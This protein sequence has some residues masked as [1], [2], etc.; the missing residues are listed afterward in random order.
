MHVG[1]T[2][3]NLITHTSESLTK[4]RKAN[5][6]L[7]HVPDQRLTH[8]AEEIR[9][10]SD[11]VQSYYVTHPN[12]KNGAPPRISMMA[13]HVPSAAAKNG[14]TSTVA[15][16]LNA[17]KVRN[18]GLSGST[19]VAQ[20][21]PE[22]LADFTD[23]TEAAKY[24]VFHHPE[25]L[26]LD[27]KTSANVLARIENAPA[28]DALVKNLNEQ[29]V[30]QHPESDYDGWAVGVYLL[31]QDGNRIPDGSRG[32][33]WKYEYTDETRTYMKP[34]VQQALLA[35]RNDKT[36]EGIS[37]ST[38]FGIHNV[39]ANEVSRV[40]NGAL[41][42]S[43]YQYKVGDPDWHHGRQVELTETDGR[44]L[45][46]TVRN[47]YFRYLGVFARF[48][49]Y[50]GT[51]LTPIRLADIP[52]P[53]RPRS[54][55][56]D[57]VYTSY[58]ATV[59]DRP[60]LMGI[61]IK[62]YEEAEFH[63]TLPE[64]ASA[65]D[66]LCGT[67]GTGS[68]PDSVAS[69]ENVQAPG[70]I[71]TGV[72]NLAIPTVFL[73]F[74]I[75]SNMIESEGKALIAKVAGWV[76][77][78]FTGE[79]VRAGLFS[80]EYT[81]DAMST[82]WSIEILN[83]VIKE[84]PEVFLE[85]IAWAAEVSAE[86]G[87][88]K[89]VPVIGAI[90]EAVS[91]TATLAELAETIADVALSPWVIPTTVTST[92]DLE[93]TIHPDKN[94]YQFPVA[95]TQYK[96]VAHL[97]DTLKYDTGWM[98][99]APGNYDESRGVLPQYTFTAIPSGGEVHV[100]V[101]FASDSFWIAAYGATAK[102]P[103]LIPEKQEKLAL[104]LTITEN[105]V[106]LTTGTSYHHVSRL[107]MAAAGTHTWKQTSTAPAST[108]AQLGGNMS[109]TLE[110]LTQITFNMHN[111]GQNGNSYNVAVLGY[112]WRGKGT[113]LSPCNGGGAGAPLFTMQ[114]IQ[115]ATANPDALLKTL[116]CGL[117]APVMPGYDMLGAA[118]GG[119]FILAYTQDGTDAHTGQP[120]YH[121]HVR[122]LDLSTAGA[123]SLSN[124]PSWGRFAS[125][126][127][128]SVAVHGTEFVLAL[129]PEKEM[130]EILKLPDAPYARDGV[131]H[132][133]T[134][135]GK[136]GEYVGRLHGAVA[137]ALTR[138]GNT[139][140]VL[141]Q[142]NNRIQAFNV[143][144]VPVKYFAGS[145]SETVLRQWPEDLGRTITY[146]DMSLE[147][148]GYIYVLSYEEPGTETVQY[149]L[150]TYNPDGTKLSRTRS[151][152]AAKLTVDQWRAVYTLNYELLPP[153]LTNQRPEPSVS[154]WAAS[155]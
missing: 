76:V 130:V 120:T 135:V 114:N 83:S 89:F 1:A 138:D 144:G 91:V 100:T 34:V 58:L 37:F 118:T 43:A 116:P 44:T 150:D 88:A 71:C 60:R 7:R 98:P 21:Q 56:C 139:F 57:G 84:A 111:A 125:Q 14:K 145:S 61:P 87:L 55:A 136:Q 22:D 36:M 102:V 153:E 121:Y 42:E 29:G 123:I 82:S 81:H 148:G 62:D 92:L 18:L 11:A 51:T 4:H 20:V 137:M 152:P 13:I 63:I 53:E 128:K 31:D 122:K 16:T 108:R 9:L 110:D 2:T 127:I 154:L 95:A 74:G 85:L 132:F 117:T 105:P 39:Q 99:F 79:A 67:L 26:S 25:L 3:Y 66:I 77:E 140:L 97:T 50:Q 52:A 47:S 103:N 106:P 146:L 113:G 33:R 45:T 115:L 12:S 40:S 141:E 93:V 23:L 131:A 54:T 107:A 8:Y 119:Q 68:L 49:A 15:Q 75:A 149:R 104:E 73:T 10:P 143:N 35:H 32:Y 41:R 112:G 17:A 6:A 96:L 19:T 109:V 86:E 27:P 155:A 147:Y 70:A 134:Q 151:V 64:S 126:S 129:N 72:I 94:D 59:E 46:F 90:W 133:A 142:A 101:Q 24:I 78:V 69:F 30:A 5:P 80:A 48:L 65:V 28:F 124:L 38:Q